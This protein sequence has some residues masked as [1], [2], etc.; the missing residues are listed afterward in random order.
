[1]AV[2]SNQVIAVVLGAAIV[3]ATPAWGHA[4]SGRGVDAPLDT[5]QFAAALDVDLTASKRVVRGLY[6]RDFIVGNGRRRPAAMNSRCATPARWRMDDASPGHRN[7]LSPSS[8]A[9][10]P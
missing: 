2:M 9:Q 1:M 6:A 7:R 5:V 4:Q 10:V 8:W 3:S